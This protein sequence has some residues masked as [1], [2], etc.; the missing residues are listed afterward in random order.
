M[1]LFFL[2]S[3]FFFGCSTQT[4]PIGR[5]P[6]YAARQPVVSREG[7]A[8][9]LDDGG[10][11]RLVPHVGRCLSLSPGAHADGVV[12]AV[13]DAG[14]PCRTFDIGDVNAVSAGPV[15]RIAGKRTVVEVDPQLV[16]SVTIKTSGLK[17]TEFAPNSEPRSPA[18][19]IVGSLLM[20][21]GVAGATAFF[22][23]AGE[24]ESGFLSDLGVALYA[25]AGGW[26]LAAGFGGGIPLVV[27]GSRA[28]RAPQAEQPPLPT[29]TTSGLGVRWAFD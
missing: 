14:L 6:D 25:V 4:I 7:V 13:E 8:V 9:S 12:V 3:I 10:R 21:A 28:V 11:A 5:M 29:F 18:M 22:T 15:L 20:A 17:P 26:S 23:A 24:I 1:R 27:I 16:D 19:I 2:G